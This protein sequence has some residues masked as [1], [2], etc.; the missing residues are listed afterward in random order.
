[1]PSTALIPKTHIIKA[2]V[3]AELPERHVTALGEFIDN[4][5]GEAAGNA[6]TVKIQFDPYTIV[7]EDDG[8]G[9]AEM[10]AMFTIGDSHSRLSSRDIGQFG[11]GAKVGALYLAYVMTVETVRDGRYHSYR[12][13]WERV[14][15]SGEW[16]QGYRGNGIPLEYQRVPPLRRGTRITLERRHA[17]R[18]WQAEALA[19]H[20]AHVYRPALRA[21]RRIALVQRRGRTKRTWNLHKLLDALRIEDEITASGKVRGKPFTLRAGRARNLSYRLN[22]VH[23]GF[24]HRFIVS[25]RALVE[26]HIPSQLYA[27]VMLSPAWKDSLGA[28]KGSIAKHRDELLRE[29]ERILAP[30]IDKLE[31]EAQEIEIRGFV[32]ELSH[33]T[34]ELIEKVNQ[35][36][37]R[38][39]VGAPRT[40]ARVEVERRQTKGR[41]PRD[42]RPE[43][44]TVGDK[45]EH[46]KSADSLRKKKVGVT[47]ELASLGERVAKV[48]VAMTGARVTLNKDLLY[49]RLVN[50][51]KITLL[52]TILN[53]LLDECVRDDN[54][55]A[56]LFPK[57][58]R[59]RE[60][61]EAPLDAKQ[62]VLY[63]LLSAHETVLH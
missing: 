22:G 33:D 4:A 2:L 49:V 48:S 46:G 7:V 58:H 39:G 55:A 5:L 3:N 13:D 61:G 31:G 27:E 11:Y 52:G 25:E 28:N 60:S 62:H 57:F 34:E 24:G 38:Y 9:I 29:I 32:L 18:G 30:L 26:R 50:K 14:E 54:R 16:P 56:S 19:Q 59:Y 41:H 47:V 8:R 12:V 35:D 1:M 20:L 44:P 42:A 23:I 53:A 21:G 17:T 45:G 37:G 51:E 63:D 36:A 43:A 40:R 15:K 6:D 10:N